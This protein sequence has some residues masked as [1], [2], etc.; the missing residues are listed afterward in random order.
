[1]TLFNKTIN[2][3]IHFFDILLVDNYFLLKEEWV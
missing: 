3:K 2:H 1:M